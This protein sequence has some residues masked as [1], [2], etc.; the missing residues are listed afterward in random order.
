M[1]KHS[2][3]CGTKVLDTE[4]YQLASPLQRLLSFIL[5][6]IIV[7]VVI[8]SPFLIEAIFANTEGGEDKGGIGTAIGIILI[9]AYI[10]WALLL[11]ARGSSPGKMLLGIRVIR[12]NGRPANFWIML[13][14]ELIGK[15]I[16]ELILDLGFIWIL[17]DK[18]N[19]GWHDKLVSTYVV[20]KNL[21]KIKDTEDAKNQ[22][23]C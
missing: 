1:S 7:V 2:R 11:F 3:I 17:I 6:R 16:S 9:G 22:V 4:I 20:N 18:D 21:K 8:L 15:Y 5:D 10:V 23:I 14:R 13:I 19:Q 12:E